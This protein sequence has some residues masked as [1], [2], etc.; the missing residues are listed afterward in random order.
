MLANEEVLAVLLA[1]VVVGSIFGAAQLIVPGGGER[2]AALG[3]LNGDCLIGPYPSRAVNNSYVDLCLYVY[4]HMG[5]PIYYRVIYRVGGTSD[6][7]S[8]STSSPAPQIGEWRGVLGDNENR[9][10]KISAI[11]YSRSLPAN[12]TMIFELWIYD[13]NNNTW[14]YSGVWNHLYIEVMPRV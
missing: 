14:I 5:R 8:N 9:T 12:A 10:F 11:V 7:P 3:L 1:L 13:V 6:L 4:N 2:F